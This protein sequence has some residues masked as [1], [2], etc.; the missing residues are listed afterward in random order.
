MFAITV[1][2]FILEEKVFGR[3]CNVHVIRIVLL[4]N[5]IQEA[6]F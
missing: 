6:V 1:E 4:I 5:F 3:S 2:K